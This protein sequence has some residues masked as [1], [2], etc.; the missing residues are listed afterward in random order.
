ME[1]ALAVRED[2]SLNRTQFEPT[3]TEAA[4]QICSQLVPTGLLP[5]HVR[6]PQA[7]LLQLILGREHGLTMMQSL[8]HMHVVGNVPAMSVE[9]LVAKIRKSG[10]CEKFEVKEFSNTKVTVYSKRKDTGEEMSST[11]TIED[12]KVA[13][14]AHKDNWKHYPRR[15][16][17]ARAAGDVAKTLYQDVVLGMV[18]REEQIDIDAEPGN[19]LPTIETSVAGESAPATNPIAAL[20][21][22]ASASSSLK[23][24]EPQVAAQ[25][26]QHEAEKAERAEK[27]EAK[28]EQ[29]PPR[30]QAVPAPEKQQ[31]PSEP[32]A[33][34]VPPAPAAAESAPGPGELA[35][36]DFNA[37][38]QELA[39]LQKKFIEEVGDK[40]EAQSFWTGSVSG[41]HGVQSLKGV[42]TRKAFDTRLDQAKA[43]ID[44][45]KIGNAVRTTRAQLQAALGT[46]KATQALAAI[47]NG[48]ANAMRIPPPEAHQLLDA[49]IREL[50]KLKPAPVV[51]AVVVPEDDMSWDDT[52]EAP[53]PGSNG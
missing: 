50:D 8:M 36:E 30:A 47:P 11:W 2:T 20:K 53:E 44:R 33:P 28:T 15:M 42:R 29:I 22:I 4:L 13:G 38:K 7:A 52:D 25:Q 18:T 26:A 23:A 27:R 46:V 12:A 48:N 45:A 49:L 24:I 9:L 39:D 3:T 32:Q 40:K 35:A 21:A 17:Y 16:L 31:E 34:E 5:K 37:L 6:T 51:D 43:L 19:A 41:I 14:L 1:T 10:V